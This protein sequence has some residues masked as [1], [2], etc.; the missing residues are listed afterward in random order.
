M[1][2]IDRVYHQLIQDHTNEKLTTQQVA[3]IAGLTRGVVSSYLSQL[4]AVGKVEKTGTRPIYWQ[5]S[6]ARTAFDEIV[7]HNGSLKSIIARCLEAIVYPPN[8][9][10]LLITG[11][12]GVGKSFLAQIIFEE[13]KRLG[14]IDSDAN[15]VVLNAADYANNPELLSSVLFGYKKGAFTGATSDKQGLVDQANNGYLFLD[16]VHRLPQS[17]QE[18]LFSLLDTG[19]FYPL[20]ESEQSRFA[21]VRFLFATT[22]RVDQALLKTLLRRIPLQVHLP[23]F[24]NR[25]ISERIE[26]VIHAFKQEAQRVQRPY[27]LSV[28]TVLRLI[29]LNRPGNVG[30]IQNE[31]KLICAAAFAKAQTDGPIEIDSD[32]GQTIII[33]SQTTENGDSFNAFVN[34]VLGLNGS[35][36]LLQTELADSL[37][38]NA[39]ISEQNLIVRKATRQIEALV[40]ETLL[41]STIASLKGAVNSTLV[42]QYG[43]K[44]PE[45]DSYWRQCAV[46]LLLIT[47][48]GASE[49][50]DE[51]G[52]LMNA[53]HQRYPR[54]QYVYSKFV[55]K[56]VID[57]TSPLLPLL[58]FP[59]LANNVAQIEEIHFNA[60]LL[61]HG[62]ETAA[63]IQNVV[64]NLCGNYL[65]EAFDMP[66]DVSVREINQQ[67]QQYLINQGRSQKGTIVLFD[68]GSLNQMFSEI[69]N[70]SDQELLLVN[71]LTTAMAL[72]VGLR[73]Q[74]D[75]GFETIA[76]AAQRFG[77]AT[78]TQYF[79]G[80]SNQKNVIV[81]CMSGVGLSEEI[82]KMMLQTLSGKLEIIT[83][84]YK[85]LN[86]ILENHDRRFFSNTQLV[87]TT[88]DIQ[89]DLDIDIINIYDIM[90]KTGY[91][92]MED[93]LVAS[94]ESVTGVK[95]LMNQFVKFF[96]IEGVRDRLQFMN[97][98]IVIEEV[99]KITERY[100]EYYGIELDGK[101]KLNLYMHLSLMIE[102][103]MLTSRTADGQVAAYQPTTPKEI[104]FFSVSK[105]IFK[106][107]EM[108][109]NITIEDYEISLM[110]Q[111]LKP[112]I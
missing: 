95:A 73:I 39:V 42:D 49:E 5:V 23:A 65:F 75:D 51:P 45:S 67:V 83:E 112:Y 82:K 87:I 24:I 55:E 33:D 37:S 74:R 2:A 76:Q 18:K 17:S 111:L 15:L 12:S 48:A 78:G 53:I 70:S 77:E 54:S 92:R 79:E 91:R 38:S 64:N 50:L 105:S 81:S 30:A 21:N 9:F 35:L 57:S 86:T 107:I 100:Q 101:I 31:V 108:K 68:M 88:T 13:A 71:N 104:E 106:G 61:A 52:N 36:R 97:P 20:G 58:F 60:I 93:L 16:E 22:E 102:R 26:L 63:S 96:S 19:R 41:Q 32:D 29:Q 28:R 44:L 34:E 66:I 40:D 98:D 84:D 43:L 11:P 8:G 72:D 1:K 59:L 69:R 4:H 110:Y 7:G 47:V 85:D 109:Y 89:S 80:L 6:V 25:P 62:R 90:E 103:M 94:G 3:D 99:Q 14:V 27:L 10:P 56:L 46:T